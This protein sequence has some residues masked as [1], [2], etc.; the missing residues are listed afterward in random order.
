MEWKIHQCPATL[1]RGFKDVLVALRDKDTKQLKVVQVWQKT[2]NSMSNFYEASLNEREQKA[3]KVLLSNSRFS[4]SNA[5][6]RDQF[7]HWASKICNSLIADGYW[8]DL[9]DPMTGEPVRS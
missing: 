9:I 5:S 3:D 4:I 7:I 2:Q 8:S 6:K 1:E